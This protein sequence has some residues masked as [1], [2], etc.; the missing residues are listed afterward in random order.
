MSQLIVKYM[1][2]RNNKRDITGVDIKITNSMLELKV[3]EIE[4]H[5]I[6]LCNIKEFIIK[7]HNELK[8]K[9]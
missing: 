6:P 5:Y 1:D 8:G 7:G 9:V 2:E 3:N 4:K